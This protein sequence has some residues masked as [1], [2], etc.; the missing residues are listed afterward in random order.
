MP[1]ARGIPPLHNRTPIAAY[2]K[3]FFPDLVAPRPYGFMASWPLCIISFSRG[4]GPP[5]FEASKEH[6]PEPW[7]WK[8]A[9][10]EKYK[11]WLKWKR[12]NG[13]L[14]RAEERKKK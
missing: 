10:S 9:G 7:G 5:V 1:L 14:K 13:S 2:V 11:A 3:C 4:L 12:F 6:H 8:W